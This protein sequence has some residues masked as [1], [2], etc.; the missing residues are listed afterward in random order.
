MAWCLLDAIIN[1]AC[2]LALGALFLDPLALAFLVLGSQSSG[3]FDVATKGIL[4]ALSLF[5]LP[6]LCLCLLV[7][8]TL[9]RLQKG[10]SALVVEYHADTDKLAGVVPF[11]VA[12]ENVQS[13]QL[14]NLDARVQITRRVSTAC[15]LCGRAVSPWSRVRETVGEI[16]VRS[17]DGSEVVLEPLLVEGL[18]LC[19]RE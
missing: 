6:S 3:L 12:R 14:E 16:K 11:V 7:L 1:L 19:M 4:L 9:Q 10:L 8:K 5:P 15:T 13:V 18:R 2:F 17:A